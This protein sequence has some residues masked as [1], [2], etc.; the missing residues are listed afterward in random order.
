MMLISS[1]S[2][3]GK[4]HMPPF[5]HQ[6]TIHDG[7][8]IRSIVSLGDQLGEVISCELYIP[9]CCF[10]GPR[11][12]EQISRP[13]EARLCIRFKTP[14]SPISASRKLLRYILASHVSWRWYKKG[15]F[16]GRTCCHMPLM[17][18][19][20]SGVRTCILLSMWGWVLATM[21]SWDGYDNDSKILQYCTQSFLYTTLCIYDFSFTCYF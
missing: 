9:D 1:Q 16:G 12:L 6:D 10:A 4:W 7:S 15:W 19:F 3:T 11:F 20:L 13:N 17:L 2:S 21:A 14:L 18:H 5:L 8:C